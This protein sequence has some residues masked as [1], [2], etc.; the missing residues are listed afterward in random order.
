MEVKAKLRYLRMSPKKVRLVADLIRGENAHSAIVQLNHCSRKAKG[1]ILKLLN[2]A[3]ANAK[4]NFKLSVDGL[5]IQSVFVDQGPVLKRWMPRA[6]GKA[7]EIRKRTSHITIVLNSNIPDN[8]EIV[9]D[10][11]KLKK[12]VIKKDV[13][14]QGG[15]KKTKK[16]VNKSNK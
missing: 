9:I 16:L 3:V 13:S 1:P 10:N 14:A 12:A 6:F 5:Y 7:S 15:L 4:N 2:S 8:G 11:K